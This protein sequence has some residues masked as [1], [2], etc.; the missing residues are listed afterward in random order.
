MAI[1]CPC[2]SFHTRLNRLSPKE[3]NPA[4][5]TSLGGKNTPGNPADAEERGRSEQL[6]Q[7]AITLRSEKRKTK[8]SRIKSF[9][10]FLLELAAANLEEIFIV[11]V[12]DIILLCTSY[13]TVGTWSCRT[14]KFLTSLGETASILITVLIS[15]FRYQKL[16]DASRRVPIYLDSIR[17]AW[18][19]SGILL[20][21]TVLLASP[22]FVLNIKEMSQNVTI[23]GSGCPP[24]FFQCNK[25]NCP[26][27]NGIY[28]YLFILLFNL[29]PLIIVTVTSCLIIMVLLSQRK[30]VAPVVNASSQTA[31]RSKCQKFQRSTIAVLTAMGLFQVDWTLNLIFQLTSSPGAFTSGAEIKFFISSSYTA[32]SPY[33]YGIGNNLFSL[34]K[35]RKT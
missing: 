6:S 24:D 21:F 10:L 33:V 15:I 7:E 23:N 12:Y 30:T 27:L 17:S 28:K 8:F 25:D 29:L 13:A 3:R 35:F 31:Q 9:E 34:K 16:R 2:K 22:I 1:I 18:T 19:V 5:A 14:L 20:M 26:E 4:Y 11:N 32:I